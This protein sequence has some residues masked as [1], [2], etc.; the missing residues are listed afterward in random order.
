M[1]PC[2]PRLFRIIRRSRAASTGSARSKSASLD[3]S[4][5]NTSSQSSYACASTDSIASSRCST[6]VS[7]TGVITLM[8]GLKAKARDSFRIRSRSC[9]VAR[10]RSN[11]FWYSLGAMERRRT[12]VGRRSLFQTVFAS[13]SGRRY[14]AS[15][16]WPTR[17]S[18]DFRRVC[19]C[20]FSNFN[21]RRYFL[22]LSSFSS[23]PAI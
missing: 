15:N 12:R 17:R 4:S 1:P 8:N 7:K 20:S 14:G 22:S 5:I 6:G 10:W 2:C 11:H 19:L 18:G 21:S 9:G 3:P 23:S 13:L 16:I